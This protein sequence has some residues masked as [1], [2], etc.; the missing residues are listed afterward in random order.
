[1]AQAIR[2]GQWTPRELWHMKQVEI[3]MARKEQQAR[4]RLEWEQDRR[5]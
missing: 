5:E 2:S 1:M 4:H 3:E